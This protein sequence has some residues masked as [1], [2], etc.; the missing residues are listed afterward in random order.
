MEVVE[1]HEALK[2]DYRVLAED[3]QDLTRMLGRG[4]DMLAELCR[5]L[6]IELSVNKESDPI[7]QLRTVCDTLNKSFRQL[8]D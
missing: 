7:D 5:N 2:N 8:L 6:T 4:L 1:E 3:R